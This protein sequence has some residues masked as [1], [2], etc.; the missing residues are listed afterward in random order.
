V[1]QPRLAHEQ[2]AFSREYHE[3]LEALYTHVLRSGRAV[4]GNSFLQLGTMR[5][6]EQFVF[7][8]TYPGAK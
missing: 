3:E 6:F 2:R 8:N 5:A 1:P 4:F 7:E